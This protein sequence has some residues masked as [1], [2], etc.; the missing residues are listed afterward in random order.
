MEEMREQETALQEKRDYNSQREY[1]WQKA[2]AEN[3][4]CD[5]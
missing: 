1:P 4:K 2:T 5:H 3:H